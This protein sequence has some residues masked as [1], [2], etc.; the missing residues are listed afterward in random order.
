MSSFLLE[1][2]RRNGISWIPAVTRGGSVGVKVNGCES[3]FFLPS[4]GMRQG[5]PLSPLLFNLVVDAL[6]RVLVKAAAGNL[7][8]G[9]C[10]TVCPGVIMCLQYVDD[11]ILFLENSIEEYTNLTMVLTC[12]E[13]VSGMKINYTKSEL[14][15]INMSVEET[16]PFVEDLGCKKGNFII[17]YPVIHLHYDKLRREDIQPLIDKI[18]KGITCWRGKLL[19]YKCRLVLIHTCLANI[20]DYL[21]SFFKFPKWATELIITQMSNCLW[22]DFEGHRK[23]ST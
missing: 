9:L 3:D 5:D 1:V 16:N 22:N 7:I 11:T 13:K 15:S 10:P 14:I 8:S 18:L 19:S 20:P 23:R 4:K 17:K 2:L 6:R 21:L 12:F